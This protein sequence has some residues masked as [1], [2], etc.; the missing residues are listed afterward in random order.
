M[1]TERKCK[2]TLKTGQCSQER[3][4]VA[5]L[6]SRLESIE[7]Q[8]FLER[9]CAFREHHNVVVLRMNFHDG[10]HWCCPK[11]LPRL[12]FMTNTSLYWGVLSNPGH[13]E[14]H[15]RV[16]KRRQM[17]LERKESPKGVILLPSSGVWM[18]STWRSNSRVVLPKF[19]FPFYFHAWELICTYVF[20]C[21]MLLNSLF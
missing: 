15:K 1:K 8:K 16:P 10:Q 19:L 13:Q 4:C 17:K 20:D 18:S 3:R 9:S 14:T 2:K 6:R 5:P 12:P 11:A 7:N 21:Y